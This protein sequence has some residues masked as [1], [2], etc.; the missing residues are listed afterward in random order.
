MFGGGCRREV[1]ESMSKQQN[2][3][4]IFIAIIDRMMF[5][6]DLKVNKLTVTLIWQRLTSD[7]QEHTAEQRLLE[8]SSLDC[9]LRL[10]D[11]FAS[12]C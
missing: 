4:Y 9:S 8:H 10:I 3:V 12:W 6:M 11:L 1:Q 5:A 7:W 2:S